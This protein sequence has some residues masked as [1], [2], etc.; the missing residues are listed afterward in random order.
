MNDSSTHPVI[1]D[2]STKL[3]SLTPKA[4]TLG[5][6][7]MQN[8]SKAVFMTTKELAEACQISEAT[9][10]RFVSTLG[11]KGYSEFQEALKDFV[12]TGLSLPE[13]A[14][15]KGIKE[16]GT[17]R[18]HRGILEELNNL[19]YLYENINI[20]TMNQ[21]VDRLDKSHTVYVVGS[22]LSYTF[23]YYLGWSLT[24]IRKG[25]HI[26]KGSDST[27]MDML[28]NAHSNCLVILM[29]TT[30][31]PNELIKLSKMIRRSGHTLLTMTDS[32]I[33][34]VIQFADLSLVVPA[35]SI[36]F[37]GNVSG[38]LAVIQFIVQ[39]LA[40]R[41]GEELTRYQK[42]LEQVYLEND[43]LFNLEPK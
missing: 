31:Y 6:Y 33:C 19:K 14:A 12:N 36:P 17:D 38:M 21:F 4:Q 40:N 27:S 16:P 8:P 5:T 11:Y 29:A 43:I 30:R 42:Q 25:V 35:R 10:V 13:R 26:M 24:K 28:T 20:D 34:P 1:N 18:L 9:V 39:E 2:I 32:S 22:R 3:D 7:I 41:K 23:A 15:I 37:I